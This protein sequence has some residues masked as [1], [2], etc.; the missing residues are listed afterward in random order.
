MKYS[1]WKAKSESR[2]LAEAAGKTV[3][4]TFGRFQPPTSGHQ[5][6][7]DALADAASKAGAQAYLLSLIHI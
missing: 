5:K 3:A 4:F 2:T 7:V 1:D 6:L